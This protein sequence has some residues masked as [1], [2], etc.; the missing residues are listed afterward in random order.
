MALKQALK[1]QMNSRF[2]QITKGLLSL[3]VVVMFTVALIAGQARAN[4]PADVSA[5]ADFGPVVQTN[6]L[7]DAESLR[8]IHSLPYVIDI[9]L[10]L[11]IDLE[12]SLH[13]L[14]LRSGDAADAGSD[15][16]PVQ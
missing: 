6:L 16:S 13:D 14:K 4:L 15:D 10:A 3:A 2:D 1:E 8:K 9:I 7:L 11:P 12:L 5:T